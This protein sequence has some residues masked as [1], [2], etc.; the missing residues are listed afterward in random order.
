MS[1]DKIPERHP[2]TALISTRAMA[3]MHG[4]CV[5]SVERW[6]E[7]GRLPEP[8]RINR[9]KFWPAGTMAKTDDATAS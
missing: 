7:A 4:V 5:R 9:R 1:T 3:E 2:R 6:V 8:M